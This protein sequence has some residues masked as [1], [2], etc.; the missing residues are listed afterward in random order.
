M[1][2]LVDSLLAL[3]FACCVLL[4]ISFVVGNAVLT[5]VDVSALSRFGDR[6]IV[7]LWTGSIVIAAAMTATSLIAPVVSLLSAAVII[8]MTGLAVALPQVRSSVREVLG[9]A[10]PWSIVGFAVLI[11]GVAFYCSSQPISLYDTG[12]YHAGAIEWLSRYGAVKG[13]AFLEYRFGFAS[14]WFALDAAFGIGPFAGHMDSLTGGY[15]LLLASAHLVV[16]AA[17][18]GRAEGHLPDW[19]VVIAYLVVITWLLRFGVAVSP[20]PDV[21]VIVLVIE[22]AWALLLTTGKYVAGPS[23][24]GLLAPQ[25]VPLILAAGALSMKLSAAPLLAVAVLFYARD[26]FRR[27]HL[28]A[29]FAAVSLTVLPTMLVSFFVSG[30]PLFPSP[31]LCTDQ[32]WSVGGA[33]AIRD[34]IGARDFLRWTGP[35]PE[36]ANSWNWLPHWLRAEPLATLA[37]LSAV[38]AIAGCLITVRQQETEDWLWMTFIGVAGIG[39]LLALSPTYRFMLGFAA[40][41]TAYFGAWICRR[42]NAH[43]FVL[44]PSAVVAVASIETIT[45]TDYH[46]NL[47]TISARLFALILPVGVLALV[48][49]RVLAKRG[50]A[51]WGW[52]E[53][54]TAL[55]RLPVS[56][57]ICG[58]LIGTSS[59]GI[60]PNPRPLPRPNSISEYLSAGWSPPPLPSVALVSRRV[61]DLDYFAPVAG[62]QCWADIPCAYQPVPTGI[63]LLDPSRGLQG[64]IGT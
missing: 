34:Q 11:L 20:S 9:Q 63:H 54:Q 14:S 25:A 64:G 8:A 1:L 19:F 21:P 61:N 39:Y 46:S 3:A 10:R 60:V 56:A 29:G 38:I 55:F 51:W 22:A 18:I 16:S 62:E 48:A 58:I 24:L 13:I 33:A 36:Y 47:L 57:A 15:T 35:V 32:R 43:P 41:P 2:Q 50:E 28:L 59:L 44:I 23:N 49:N 26:A 42:L 6:T 4:A 45:L 40:T 52:A 30:C 5:V 31:L 37:I 27:F 53:Q 7:A 17:R 12:L